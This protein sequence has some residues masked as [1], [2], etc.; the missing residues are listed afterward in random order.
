MTKL[1]Y[2]PGTEVNEE[3][4]KAATALLDLS[5]PPAEDT[6]VQV[7]Q[8]YVSIRALFVAYADATPDHDM[9]KRHDVYLYSL[10]SCLGGVVAVMK[11]ST[12]DMALKQMADSV[13]MIAQRTL[14]YERQ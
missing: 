13:R 11:R 7:Q 14:D 10:I 9:F 5:G 4:V 2:V 1:I 8:L 3:M 6:G 12:W